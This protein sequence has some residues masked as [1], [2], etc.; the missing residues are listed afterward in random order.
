MDANIPSIERGI[1]VLLLNAIISITIPINAS[2]VAIQ[3]FLL[4]IAVAFNV[5]DWIS[6]LI[7][8]LNKAWYSFTN[9]ENARIPIEIYENIRFGSLY[10]Y[11]I[12]SSIDV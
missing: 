3:S 1:I 2:D 10:S 5:S 9:I 8:I 7:L 11:L 6:L 4:S 12:I